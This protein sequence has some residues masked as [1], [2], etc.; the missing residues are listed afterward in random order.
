ML[1][2]E[3][4]QLLLADIV[5]PLCNCLSWVSGKSLCSQL[6]TLVI[7]KNVNRSALRWL[8]WTILYLRTAILVNEPSKMYLQCQRELY[9]RIGVKWRMIRLHSHNLSQLADWKAAIYPL[10]PWEQFARSY[11]TL[12]SARWNGPKSKK[13]DHSKCSIDMCAWEISW[14]LGCWRLDSRF[15]SSSSIIL[16]LEVSVPWKNFHYG[17]TFEDLNSLDQLTESRHYFFG[18]NMHCYSWI[19]WGFDD[20]LVRYVKHLRTFLCKIHKYNEWQ[21]LCSFKF[22]QF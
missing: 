17:C 11:S 6:L 19:F 7:V 15:W 5:T 13:L 20:K 12:V 18:R 4:F 8:Q 14:S 21:T 3:A 9:G 22:N 1:W 16:N 10:T 2:T